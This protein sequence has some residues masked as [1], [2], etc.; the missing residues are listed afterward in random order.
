MIGG[1]WK[2]LSE[3]DKD[4]LNPPKNPGIP[5]G[6]LYPERMGNQ[7]FKNLVYSLSPNFLPF[8]SSCA[9]PVLAV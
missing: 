4:G 7:V 1:L 5:L 9:G 6:M 3:Q 8:W 2:C